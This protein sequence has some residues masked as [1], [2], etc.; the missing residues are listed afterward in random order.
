MMSLVQSL[1]EF[2]S[3]R[4]TAAEEIFRQFE[5][6]IVQY[7]KDGSSAATG[8][9]KLEEKHKHSRYE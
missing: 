6:S 8:G 4:L 2:I 5:Q 7:K 9:Q 3:E 1:R